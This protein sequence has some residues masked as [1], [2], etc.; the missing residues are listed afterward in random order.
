MASAPSTPSR[1]LG[2]V[3]TWIRFTIGFLI[4]VLSSIPT[5]LALLLLVP[6]R[7][8]RIRVGNI[9]GKIVGS[10]ATWLTGTRVTVH[11]HERLAGSRPCIFVANHAS[12]LDVFLGVWLCPMGGVGVAKKELGRV[13]VFGWIFKLSGH[14]LVDRANRENAIAAL[15]EVAAL[16]RTYGMSLWIWPEGTRSRDGRLLHFKKGFAHLA[17]A[18]RL[19]IVPIVV[20]SSHLRW[21][22]KSFRLVPGKVDI[23]VLPAIDTTEWT[24][25][26][27][28]AHINEVRQVFIEGLRPEQ[29]PL[30][31]EDA[32]QVAG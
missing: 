8:L 24:A 15:S 22:N 18:T 11:H 17:L 13:P 32:A 7:R 16:I 29:R 1:P 12:A 31:A 21:P 27:L 28:D 20:H 5:G 23:D 3:S 14:L 6:W 30:D 4:I 25:E 19:P 10:S 9:Y 2:P 26:N